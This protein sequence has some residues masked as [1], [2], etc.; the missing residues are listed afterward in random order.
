MNTNRVNFPLYGYVQKQQIVLSSM[1]GFD[2]CKTTYQNDHKSEYLIAQYKNGKINGEARL[3]EHGVLKLRWKCEDGIQ[4]GK[5]YVYEDG[6]LQYTAKCAKGA[7]WNGNMYILN[8]PSSQWLYIHNPVSKEIEYI[9]EYGDDEISREGWGTE[10]ENGVLKY[11]GIWKKNELVKI[12][13]EFVNGKMIEYSSFSLCDNAFATPSVIY[14][15][16]Y[17]NS[18][19]LHYPRHGKGKLISPITGIATW[20]GTFE[21]DKQVKGDD[22]DEE[23]KYTSH[24]SSPITIIHDSNSLVFSL[25]YVENLHVASNSCN[26][27]SCVTL[28]FSFSP[29]LH[30]IQ[31]DDNCFCF[32]QVFKLFDN[33]KIESI[34]IGSMCFA[35]RKASTFD[36][37][38]MFQLKHLPKLK[39]VTIG[40][41]SFAQY[42]VFSLNSM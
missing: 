39:T 38:C 26:E 17:Y 4:C 21:I 30:S 28:D 22:C 34:T 24:S 10:Y 25:T 18:I 35:P 6:V 9:G 42:S 11:C 15:G 16:D 41:E 27:T 23:G 3:F 12:T 32:T 40:V 33:D 19:N 13:K 14:Y 29:F 37:E 7:Q 5:F 31:I 1:N 36:Q 8:T 20:S 2:I